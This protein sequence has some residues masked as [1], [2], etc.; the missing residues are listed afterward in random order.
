MQ[1]RERLRE[2]RHGARRLRRRAGLDPC[3]VEPYPA[4]PPEDASDADCL[5]IH[6]QGARSRAAARL[7]CRSRPIS[8]RSRPSSTRRVPRPSSSTSTGRWRRSST[9]RPRLARSPRRCDG[10]RA[11][12]AAASAGAAV[13]SGRPVGV[14][15]RS[16]CRST[17]C[18]YVGAL[19]ARAGGRRRASCVDL[20]AEPVGRRRSPPAADEAE[21]RA[22][23][24]A[25]R[26]QGRARGH[27]STGAPRPGARPR[28]RRSP[29]A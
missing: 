5:V 13:V 21:R 6:G 12:G 1:C 7:R 16:T 10:A 22:P 8:P 25:R 27:R 2:R 17:D 28:R 3:H 23:R 29:R 4:D 20:R 26:A 14:P 15:R 9:T 19:R 18:V 24:P 11:A